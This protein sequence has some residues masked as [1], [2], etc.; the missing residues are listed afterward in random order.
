MTKVCYTVFD[1]TLNKIL[2]K[3][4]CNENNLHVESTML[5]SKYHDYCFKNFNNLVQLFTYDMKYHRIDITENTQGKRCY[6]SMRIN[7]II[8]NP[9]QWIVARL[10]D[11]Q[12]YYYGSY[13]TETKANECANQIE[14]AIV[15]EN[16]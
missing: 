7:Y 3:V 5:L 6:N 14:S 13:D 2:W 12:L 16:K 8:D 11:G 4:E 9:K 1:E 15:I 10:L